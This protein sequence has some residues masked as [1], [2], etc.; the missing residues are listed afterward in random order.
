MKQNLLPIIVQEECAEVIQAIS[1]V[2]RF[3]PN[4]EWEG[5][6]NKHNLEIELGQLICCIELLVKEWSL[7]LKVIEKGYDEKPINIEK[8]SREY[9]ND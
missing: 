1:K 4:R 5:T 6:T 2:F 9:P 8:F 3:G 7:D